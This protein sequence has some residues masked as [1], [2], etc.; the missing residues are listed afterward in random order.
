MTIFQPLEVVSHDSDTQL[1]VDENLNK[2]TWQDKG[3][4]L[5]KASKCSRPPKTHKAFLQC[6][7]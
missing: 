7:I 3:K 6:T 5:F 4:D 1:Q 2:I